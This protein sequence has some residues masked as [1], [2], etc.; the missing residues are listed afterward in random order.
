MRGLRCPQ[1]V[2]AADD[3]QASFVCRACGLRWHAE[4]GWLHMVD[5]TAATTEENQCGL[6]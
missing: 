5:P 2:P 3:Q 1:M 4:L 6:A